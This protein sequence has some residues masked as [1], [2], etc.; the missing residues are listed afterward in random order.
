[1]INCSCY[2]QNCCVNNALC[3]QATYY[4]SNATFC[5]PKVVRAGEMANM[6]SMMDVVLMHVTVPQT[7]INEQLHSISC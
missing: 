3:K 5:R 6:M 7:M 1:M 2:N 4:I